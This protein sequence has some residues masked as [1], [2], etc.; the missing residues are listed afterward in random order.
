MQHNEYISTTE[1]AEILGLDRTQVFRLVKAGK[2]PAERIG[3]NFAIKKSD[4]GIYGGE[5]TPEQKKDIEKGV[6]Q[7]FREYGEALKKLGDA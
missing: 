6:D 3:R 1:A 2:I 5:L 7:V 4:L